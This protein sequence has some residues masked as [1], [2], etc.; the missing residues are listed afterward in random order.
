MTALAADQFARQQALSHDRSFC[1]QAPAGSGKTELLT[2]RLLKLLSVCEKPEQIL[3][4]TFTRKAAGEMRNRLISTLRVASNAVKPGEVLSA[5]AQLTRKLALAALAR[6]GQQG[7]QLLDKPDQLRIITIDSFTSY[8]TA[9]LP[10]ASNFGARPELTTDMDPLFRQAVHAT[11]AKLDSD[12]P[13]GSGLTELLPHLHNNLQGTEALL[14]N[15]L[16]HRADW[17]PQLVPLAYDPARERQ[18]LER[19]MHSVLCE[20][21]ATV[22]AQVSPYQAAIMALVDF[23]HPYLHAA[24]DDS[25]SQ[26]CGTSVLPAATADQVP[27]WQALAGF[28]L[29]VDGLFRNTVTKKQGFLAKGDCKN[30]D[31]VAQVQAQ[32]AAFVALVQ[33]MDLA[34]TLPAWQ[35]LRCLPPPSYLEQSW[36]VL[37]AL[38]T[39]LPGLAGELKVAMTSAGMID[40]VET[41]LAALM[42]LGTEDQP[43]DLALLLDYRLQHILVDE[44]QDTSHTQF[45]L[46][47]KLV[48]GWQ[49]GDGRTLFIVGDG[50]QSCYRFRNAD[51]SLF[52]RARDEGIGPVQLEPLQLS[53]NFRSCAAVVDWVNTAFAAAFPARNDIL[54]GGVSYTPCIASNPALPDS[55]VQCV[56]QIADPQASTE[57]EDDDEDQLVAA[58]SAQTFRRREAEEVA[59][60]CA[61]LG[62]DN[63]GDSIAI[64]VR[65]R[66]HLKYIVQSLRSHQLDWNATDIDHLLSYQELADL[67]TLL[68]TL[69]NTADITA[70]L[71]LLRSPLVG[72]QLADL[73]LLA[74]TSNQQACTLWST[75][76]QTDDLQTSVDAQPRLRRLVGVISKARQL[77]QALPLRTLLELTWL[78]LGGASVMQDPGLRPNLAKYLDLVEQHAHGNDIADIHSFE[79][80]L[81][82]SFGSASNPEVKLQIMTIHKAKG[83]EFDHVILPGL[84]MRSR[85][86]SSPLLRWQSYPD[87]RGNARLLVA[88]KQQRGGADEPLYDFLSSEE[89]LRANHELTRLLY[90]GVTRAIKTAWLFGTV[91]AGSKELE[92]KVGSGSLLHGLLP[93]LLA[94]RTQLQVELQ[95]VS[96]N[97]PANANSGVAP[98]M[99]GS[100]PATWTSP[101]PA[102]LLTIVRSDEAA[103]PAPQDNLLAR[104]MGE[105]VHLGLK[106]L[107]QHGSQWLDQSSSLPFWRKQLAS[108]CAPAELNQH[109]QVLQQHLL[110]HQRSEAGRWLFSA[111]HQHDKCELELLDYRSGYRRTWIVDRTF[112]DAYGIRWIIDYKTAVPAAHQS[113]AG[114]LTDQAS[115]YQ[116]QLQTYRSL[117]AIADPATAGQCKTALYFTA[118]DLLHEL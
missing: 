44:F 96:A 84:D 52:L 47:Q 117:L 61:H 72:L 3:A 30:K 5:H 33:E 23:V 109:L 25:F 35:S 99:I 6:D 88:L 85:S 115:R 68:R 105:L 78:E 55:G 69:L 19:S 21:M 91:K 64:L 42:A 103:E 49:P 86:D 90:I 106:M 11:L 98:Q 12:T 13:T 38:L 56:L 17:L 82:R 48:A 20:Q 93:V 77:R 27:Q 22:R 80:T 73:E 41:S 63:P 24:G 100:L 59:Q 18:Q 92:C 4:I 58:P 45:Q 34:G 66:G 111:A 83:L 16:Q 14:M 112:V 32:K 54:R 110:S 97:A 113:L 57:D 36:P 60:L 102:S 51:V 108:L 107:V 74:D 31:E 8:L 67:H 87:T 65:N 89:K 43:T 75:L 71:A 28:F 15:L 10:F 53:A 50:M 70:W 95:P 114:F 39:I 37:A 79:E 62:R 101:L 94:E 1:V 81:S 7:W 76:Q 2:Q 46:L 40:H 116:D 29:K 9:R 104:R 118:I 26:L